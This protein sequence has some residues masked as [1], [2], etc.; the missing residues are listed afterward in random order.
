MRNERAGER[1]LVAET[2]KQV[3][4]G[5]YQTYKSSRY[6][7]VHVHIHVLRTKRITA[8]HTISNNTYQI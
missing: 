7:R 8:V 5:F 3:T 1:E 4:Q 2:I 6:V